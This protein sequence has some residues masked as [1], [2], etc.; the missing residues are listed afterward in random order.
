MKQLFFCLTLLT[1][2][3]AFADSPTNFTPN[4]A[5]FENGIIA[6]VNNDVVTAQELNDA[7]AQ[8][9]NQARAQGNPAPDP[10]VI[11]KQVLQTLIMQK[12][13]LQLAA[14]N[15]IT[16]SDDQINQVIASIAKQNNFTIAELYQKLSAQGIDQNFY[17]NSIR[18][19]LIVQQL[20]QAEVAN[21][22]VITPDQINN[23]LA[24]QARIQNANTQYDVA[25]ILIAFP[26]SNPTANDYANTEAKANN[27]L[28]AIN[29]GM[30]FAEAA[31]QYSDSSDAQSGG[32][33]GY[34]SL[35][36]LPTAFIEPVTTLKV[37]EVS[38]P[39]ATD[40]GFNIIKLLGEKGGTTNQAHYVTE[41]HIQEIFIKTNPIL[42]NSQIKAEM[43]RIQ[44][45]LANG[46][47]FTEL[48][49]AYSEN[50]FNNQNGG[51][52][53][54]VNPVKLNPVLSAYIESAS[55]GQVSN[56]I[57]TADG[58]YLLKLLGTRQVNDTDAYLRQQAQQALF[59]Q[60]ANEALLAWQAQIRSMSYIK[61]LDPSLAD[62]N[63]DSGT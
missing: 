37:G 10:L 1:M 36:Q 52:M 30:P 54:W 40:S 15:N 55:V 29:G 25:H 18:T 62:P 48:A 21:A 4:Q 46:K 12:I 56:P 5:S 17:K 53:G 19:Q 34:Q 26:N 23:Y 14:L 42:S 51:D 11:K 20:E 39:F 43:Q 60:K 31:Q 49:S 16:V 6:I 22:I 32:D 44:A 63:D 13:A 50:Y 58:W 57:Q 2:T 41:Y 61:I 9:I 27:V 3:F 59:Q 24:A 35:N 28:S 38:A 33:L 7:T 45:A 8:A 47:S